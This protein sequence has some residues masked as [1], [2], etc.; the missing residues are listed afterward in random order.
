MKKAL[1]VLALSIVMTFAGASVAFADDQIPEPPSPTTTDQTPTSDEPAGGSTDGTSGSGAGDKGG[2][3]PSGSDTDSTSGDGT[4]GSAGGEGQ[5]TETTDKPA[6]GTEPETPPEPI[7]LATATVAIT[8]QSYTGATLEPAVTVTLGTE[9]LVR[10]TDFTVSY[11]DNKE[12]GDATA[13]VTG[14]GKYEGTASGTFSIGHAAG[15]AAFTDLKEGEWY[16]SADKGALPNTKTLF[17]DVVVT[18]G[19]MLGYEDST[20]ARTKFGPDDPVSRG[21]VVAMLY[22]LSHPD[23]NDTT[24]ATAIAAAKNG[25]QL[26]DVASGKFFTAAVNWAVEAGIV[27]GYR[28]AVER[29]YSFGADDPISREQL[30]TM[31][32]RFC[33][34]FCGLPM[35]TAETKGFTDSGK[36][37]SFATAGIQYC[38]ANKIMS[39]YSGTQAFGPGD[40]ATR[41]QMAKVMAMAIS[42]TDADEN[43]AANGW[44]TECEWHGGD[45]FPAAAPSNWVYEGGS[46][47]YKNADGTNATGFLEINGNKAHFADDGK[48]TT[49]WFKPADGATYHFA[50][51]GI[52]VKGWE[53]YDGLWHHFDETTAA[54]TEKTATPNIAMDDYARII[55]AYCG[56]DLRRCYDY[57]SIYRQVKELDDRL[58]FGPLSDD[59][60]YEYACMVRDRAVSDCY[61]DAA[62]FCLLARQCGYAA[63][64][65]GGHCQTISIGPVP[66]GWTE[67]FANGTTYVCD[68]NLMRDAPGSN[69]FMVTYD[70]AP[71][72]YYR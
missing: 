33:V 44:P 12:V 54:F 21:Q 61:G 35:V 31:V 43:I 67:V 62:M 57:M 10:D 51:N 9:T 32:G 7:S 38:L 4:S 20:G 72:E 17:L 42:L 48:M 59:I 50:D 55:A 45:S 27:S 24:D 56:Y 39:G 58:H 1:L 14:I 19:I 28:D 22:R 30:A 3:I 53:I 65:Y 36:I 66:H 18:R 34:G 41:S 5:D 46:W 8:D 52:A 71:I 63:G 13:T 15:L 68:Y 11:A 70:E 26:P 16:L 23:A 37:S 40:Q 6:E 2:S 47:Y 60:I 49:G 64:A 25:T 29:Y 69:W